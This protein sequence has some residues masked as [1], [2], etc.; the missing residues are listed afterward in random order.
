MNSICEMRVSFINI[1]TTTKNENDRQRK[2]D[3]LKSYAVR[4]RTSNCGSTT[5]MQSHRNK[6]CSQRRTENSIKR[7]ISSIS[8]IFVVIF[9]YYYVHIIIS[10]EVQR[11]RDV[12][13]HGKAV[14]ESVACIYECYTVV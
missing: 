12:A 11:W 4:E 1:K 10:N 8:V 5:V 9:V 3:S 13:K 2:N 14:G 6:I 7:K